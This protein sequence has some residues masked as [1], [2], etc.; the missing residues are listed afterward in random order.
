MGRL[1]AEEPVAV[2]GYPVHAE[3]ATSTGVALVIDGCVGEI[4]AVDVI[5]DVLGGPDHKGIGRGDLALR[6]VLAVHDIRLTPYV[7]FLGQHPY[8]GA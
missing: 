3:D 2:H 1:E 8:V 7:R 5:P 6:V 4:V